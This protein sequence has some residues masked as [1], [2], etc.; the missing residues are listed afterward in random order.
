MKVAHGGDMSEFVCV[1][2]DCFFTEGHLEFVCVTADCFFKEGH[3]EFVCVTA[4]CFF[5]EGHLE[6]VCVTADCFF[7]EGHLEFVCVTAD[8]F[9][10]EGHLEFVC[11]TADCF[12]KEGHLEFAQADYQQALEL[13]PTDATTAARVAIVQNE[14]GV[15]NYHDRDFQASAANTLQQRCSRARGIARVV[16]WV[17]AWVVMLLWKGITLFLHFF[18]ISTGYSKKIAVNEKTLN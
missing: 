15:Q 8:C 18:T 4:D 2:A 12:F 10:K 11:V 1:T 17:L 6:F 13:D 5:K 7:K 3:L 9:F 16:S 14:Y